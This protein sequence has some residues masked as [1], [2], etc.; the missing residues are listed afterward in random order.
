MPDVACVYALTTPGGTI[1]FNDGTPDQFY[2]TE[3]PVGLAG[4]PLS[5]PVDAVPYG[6]GSLSYNWWKR[7]RH[8]QIEGVFLI[9]ST[10]IEN[11]ILT[12]RNSMEAALQAALDSCA[13]LATATATL[14][15]T[16]LGGSAHSL[17]VRNDV[18]LEC[19]HDQG[20]LV[21][22]FSFGLFCDSPAIT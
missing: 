13:G 22:T 19:I 10:R 21:R 2:I 14:A 3:I 9:T 15:W 20:Y 11:G 4:A 8:I 7:G 1:F 16:P 18:P 12:I 6:D 17:T 5:T